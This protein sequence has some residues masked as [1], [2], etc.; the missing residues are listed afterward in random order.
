MG[1]LKKTMEAFVFWILY[2]PLLFLG[3]LLLFTSPLSLVYHLIVEDYRRAIFPVR[4]W[5]IMNIFIVHIA[6]AVIGYCFFKL[7]QFIEEHTQITH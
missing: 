2:M 1:K 4:G 6:M 7:S 3:V 5:G